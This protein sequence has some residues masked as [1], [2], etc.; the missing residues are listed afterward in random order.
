MFF[1]KNFKQIKFK[2]FL[3]TNIRN[4]SKFLI[5]LTYKRIKIIIFLKIKNLF[6]VLYFFIEKISRKLHYCRIDENCVI[7]IKNNKKL[8]KF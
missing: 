4:C 7:I 3:Q 5:L 2:K 8:R 1:I 6:Y